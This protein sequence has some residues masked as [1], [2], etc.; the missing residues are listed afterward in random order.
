M[1]TVAHPGPTYVVLAHI[2]R[3]NNTPALALEAVRGALTDVGF[4][5][6]IVAAPQDAVLGPLE[7]GGAAS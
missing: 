1:R 4:G 5:G 6:S 2:S 3:H 7:L